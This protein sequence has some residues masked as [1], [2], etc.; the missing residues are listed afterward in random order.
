M[1]MKY[2]KSW[3]VFESA[4]EL[5]EKQIQWL[6]NCSKGGWNFDASTGL[7]NCDGD[8]VC[9]DQ[10]LTDFLG[11]RFGEVKGYFYCDD[12]QLHSLEGAPLTAGGSFYCDNNKLTSLEGAPA[13]V[14]GSFYCYNNQLH[15]LMGAPRTVGGI[16]YCDNNQLAS[17]MGAPLTVGG[18]FFCDNNQLASLMGAPLTVGGDF[19]C[20]NNTISKHTLGRI[21]ELMKEHKDY[22]VAL[23]M[24]IGGGIPE[25][26]Q[27]LLLSAYPI[28]N[29]SGLLKRLAKSISESPDSMRILYMIKK[30]APDIWKGVIAQMESPEAGEEST[31]LGDYGF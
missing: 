20:N 3:R 4:N 6:D 1:G 15:S 5:T 21:W 31:I 27:E 8:F 26:D 16:F 12:N 28:D 25:N 9:S 19:Y 11:I 13:S 10:K 7:V 17:L 2:L 14:G 29:N 22:G 30:G 23:V 24:T 18:S